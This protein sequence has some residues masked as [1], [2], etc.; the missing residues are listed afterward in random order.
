MRVLPD[1]RAAGH[2]RVP[3][4]MCTL[5]AIWMSVELDAVLDH[6]V[7]QGAAVY[8]VGADLP[9]RRRCARRPAASDLDPLARSCA[10]PK[11]SAPITTRLGAGYARAPFTVQSADRDARLEHRVCALITALRSTTH[12]G[13]MVAGCTCA[14]A[15]TTA[16]GWIRP[17]GAPALRVI[18]QLRDAREVD[19]G[20]SATM[21]A[22]RSSAASRMP[23]PLI[24][25][26]PWRR[27]QLNR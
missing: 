24:L 20:W 23:A 14:C 6:R 9:R 2:G 7:V 13:P 26:P 1:R 12:S 18:P 11:P 15:S 4:P 22:P 8:G 10:K 5:W 25:R 19:V 16:L 21:H 3:G 27:F 17:P